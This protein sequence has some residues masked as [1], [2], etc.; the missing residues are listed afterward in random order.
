[1][2]AP[3]PSDTD[4]AAPL[5]PADLALDLAAAAL[6][7]YLDGCAER[8]PAFARRR[9]GL[10][11]SLMLHRHAAG[12]DVV[13]APINILLGILNLVCDLLGRLAAR[14]GLRRLGAWLCA[15]H[16]VL[17]TAVMQRLDQLLRV[18]LLRWPLHEDGRPTGSDGLTEALLADPRLA[19]GNRSLPAPQPHV[20]PEAAA[21]VNRLIAHYLADRTAVAEITVALISTAVSWWLFGAAAPGALGMAGPLA[22]VLALQEAVQGFPLGS[23]AGQ[24]WY[25]LF[26]VET[27]WW[28]TAATAAWLTALFAVAAAF[29]GIVA[30]P[31]ESLTGGHRRRLRK[32]V[33]AH[34][35]ALGGAEPRMSTRARYLA[36]LF[37]LLDLAQAAA[38]GMT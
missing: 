14:A 7:R 24:V 17:P 16:W 34:R 11:G 8:V 25:G 1:M 18:E 23:G 35:L 26:G 38:R 31:V 19:G 27:P 5:P 3:S 28:V 33:A 13:K 30:D 15:R 4:P 6:E 37:D 12:W 21:R 10:V 2:T 29:A 9:L 32:L 36:R 22:D 20:E